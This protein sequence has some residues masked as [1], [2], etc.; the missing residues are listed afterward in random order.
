VA[1]AGQILMSRS[2]YEDARHHVRVPPPV[3]TRGTTPLRLKRE[4]IKG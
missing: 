4:M 2:A 3:Q 1:T